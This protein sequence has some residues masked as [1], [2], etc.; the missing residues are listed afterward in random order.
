MD[1]SYFI[2]MFKRTYGTTPIQY[3]KRKAL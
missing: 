1:T 2:R 3:L